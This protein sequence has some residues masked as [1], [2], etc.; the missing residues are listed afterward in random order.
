[1]H[2]F[3]RVVQSAYSGEKFNIIIMADSQ[4]E[5]LDGKAG[6]IQRKIEATENNFG[7]PAA[8]NIKSIV[9]KIKKSV[10]KLR[11]KK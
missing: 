5:I 7:M 1:M 9:S 10:K 4:K 8:P 11:K 6:V 2:K 3:D